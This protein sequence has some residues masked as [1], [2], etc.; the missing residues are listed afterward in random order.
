MQTENWNVEKNEKLTGE[1]SLIDYFRILKALIIL[2]LLNICLYE[3]WSKSKWESLGRY[4]GWFQFR[5]C[6]SKIE[7]TLFQNDSPSYSKISP[8]SSVILSHTIENISNGSVD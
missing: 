1:L 8:H 6:E 2:F 4:A 7:T 5:F 3:L